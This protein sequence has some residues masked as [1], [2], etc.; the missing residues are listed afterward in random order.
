MRRNSF[1]RLIKFHEK[2]SA[3]DFALKI[4]VAYSITRI[5]FLTKQSVHILRFML[6]FGLTVMSLQYNNVT[7]V[8]VLLVY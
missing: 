7:E 5:V 1:S 3:K 6:Q 8:T 2:I 4:V